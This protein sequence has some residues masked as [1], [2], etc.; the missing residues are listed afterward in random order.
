MHKRGI[1]HGDVKPDN[2]MIGLRKNSKSLYFI[3]FGLAQQVRQENTLKH[4]KF[5]HNVKTYASC[6]Y[7]SIHAHMG[8]RQSRRDD[9]IALG[10]TIIYLIKGSLPWQGLKTEENEG[11][12]LIQKVAVMKRECRV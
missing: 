12:S 11:E 6:R 3:D 5:E 1:M 2:M 7:A 8:F 10:Y 4:I 9:M